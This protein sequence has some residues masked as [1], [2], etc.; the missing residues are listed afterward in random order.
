MKKIIIICI[1]ALIGFNSQAQLWHYGL[2]GG[3]SSTWLLNNNVSNIGS[4]LNYASSMSG[5]I[6]LSLTHNFIEKVGIEIDLIYAGHNQKYTGTIN[7][8]TPLSTFTLSYTDNMKTRYFDIPVLLHLGKSNGF[9][10]EVGPQFS[11]LMG[12]KEDLT[13]TPSDPTIEYTDKDF[14]SDFNSFVFAADI[15]FGYNV[16]LSGLLSLNLGL[17]FG[18]GVTDAV[19][20][21]PQSDFDVNSNIDHSLPATYAHFSDFNETTYKHETTNRA[22]GSFLVGLV[23]QIP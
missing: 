17:R 15:G 5:C 6:G 18:Y 10:F 9:Y 8:V 21:F 19:K 23:M 7:S 20:T 3:P 2:V 16:T 1:A 22:F 13:L 12:A 14:K 4:E 11:F